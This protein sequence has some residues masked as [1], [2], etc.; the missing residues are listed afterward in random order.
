MTIQKLSIQKNIQDIVFGLSVAVAIIISTVVICRVTQRNLP[1]MYFFYPLRVITY[2]CAL[3]IIYVTLKKRIPKDKFKQPR[4]PNRFLL[5]YTQFKMIIIFIVFYGTY[6]FYINTSLSKETL[7]FERINQFLDGEPIPGFSDGSGW[8]RSGESCNYVFEG[9]KVCQDYLYPRFA[10]SL[11]NLL[12]TVKLANLKGLSLFT[13]SSFIIISIYVL[14]RN[15]KNIFAFRVLLLLLISPPIIFVID[16]ANLDYAILLLILT[17]CLKIDRYATSSHQFIWILVTFQLAVALKIY[18]IIIAPLVLI[19][20]NNQHRF[21]FILVTLSNVFLGISNGWM[22][23]FEN[24][25]EPT[26]QGSGF[27]NLLKTWSG[28][29]SYSILP[30]AYIL[31]VKILMYLLCLYL[32]YRFR[33]YVATSPYLLI[34]FHFFIWSVGINHLYKNI[35]LVAG[36]ILMIIKN[37][38]ILNSNNVFVA[39]VFM[40]NI[41]LGKAD[42][43]IN[44]LNSAFLIYLILQLR[45][46]EKYK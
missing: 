9:I 21:I 22:Y 31:V 6:Y 23:V 5:C 44:V 17:L 34:S 40:S 20:L 46:S 36:I 30:T 25:P 16:R 3:A 35:F 14:T 4:N 7:F 32:A 38:I 39:T 45:I 33:F 43:L 15:L 24:V 37:E 8:L 19:Y 26:L 1:D 41:F 11:G 10:I 2:S 42:I 29:Y 12:D 28:D 13:I 27:A 18:P